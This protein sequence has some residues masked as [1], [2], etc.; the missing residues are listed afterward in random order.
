MSFFLII[1]RNVV[2]KL[3]LISKNLFKFGSLIIKIVHSILFY[4][5]FNN[6]NIADQLICLFFIINIMSNNINQRLIFY[7]CNNAH[8][9]Y[10]LYSKYL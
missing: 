5:F 4:F 10:K 7:V 1:E 6:Y 9:A 8:C 3:K 2:V